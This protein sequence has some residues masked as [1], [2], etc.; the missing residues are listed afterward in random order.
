MAHTRF[1][2]QPR[3]FIDPGATSFNIVEI[4]AKVVSMPIRLGVRRPHF[5]F[6]FVDEQNIT[7]AE[8]NASR[9]DFEQVFTAQI[10]TAQPALT[11]EQVTA[12]AVEATNQLIAGLL[13]GTDEQTH[14]AAS[15]LASAY[16]YQLLPL[17]QQ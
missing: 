15:L 3:N 13:A 2:V 6:E 4:G 9:V 17:N 10:A 5:H 1:K 14:A 8:K 12:A 7:R 11:A 16:G